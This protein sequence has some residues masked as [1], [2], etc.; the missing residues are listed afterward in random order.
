MHQSIAAEAKP[1]SISPCRNSFVRSSQEASK[2]VMSAAP[3]VVAVSAVVGAAVLATGQSVGQ[4][5]EVSPPII[6]PVVASAS[7]PSS[8]QPSP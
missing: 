7:W 6:G 4:L 2:P 8:Q 1:A 3:V 5:S